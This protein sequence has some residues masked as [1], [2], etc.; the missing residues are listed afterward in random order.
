MTTI[1]GL[2]CSIWPIII[3]KVKIKFLLLVGLGL[4]C[5][6]LWDGLSAQYH[7]LASH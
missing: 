1:Q 2:I 5:E 6:K 4:I 7:F 3:C